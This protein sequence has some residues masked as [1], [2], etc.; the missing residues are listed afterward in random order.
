[1]D[2]GQVS[3][4]DMTRIGITVVQDQELLLVVIMVV[5]IGVAEVVEVRCG[6]TT[7]ETSEEQDRG[8]G[9]R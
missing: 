9:H 8:R 5:G 3:H 1:M 2:I 4:G 6:E 7:E